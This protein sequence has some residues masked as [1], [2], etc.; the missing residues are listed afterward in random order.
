M[1]HIMRGSV[2]VYFLKNRLHGFCLMDEIKKIKDYF[3]CWI[4]LPFPCFFPLDI[5]WF[6]HHR[7][8]VQLD[9]FFFLENGLGRR[10]LILNRSVDVADVSLLWIVGFHKRWKERNCRANAVA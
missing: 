1:V 6:H 7:T 10:H 5:P 4:S 3:C 9:F 8:T 2:G